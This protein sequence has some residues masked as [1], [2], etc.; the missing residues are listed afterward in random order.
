M[1]DANDLVRTM[2]SISKN[3]NLA[4]YPADIMPGTV[5]SVSP[6]KIQVEK[7]FEITGDMIIVPE[8]LTDHEISV[9]VETNTISIKV[10]GALKEGNRVQLI[11]Q[12]GGQKFMIIDKVV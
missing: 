6:L 3:A 4:D 5:V 7:R 10:H 9:T 12:H 8:H 2:Q 1:H 11:R